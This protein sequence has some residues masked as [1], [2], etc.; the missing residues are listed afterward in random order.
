MPERT[1]LPGWFL[2]LLAVLALA[3]LARACGLVLHRP[4]LAYANNYDQI[5]YSACLDLAP[6]RPGERADTRTARRAGKAESRAEI[7]L[8]RRFRLSNTQF[9]VQ[10]TSNDADRRQT[11]RQGA[12]PTT[13]VRPLFVRLVGMTNGGSGR[14]ADGSAHRPAHHGAGDGPGRSLLL[15]RMAAGGN[16]ERRDS[17]GEDG[18]GADRETGHEAENSLK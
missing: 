9:R 4:L 5:R 11:A 12:T 14:A 18:G 15:G 17:Q 3:A 10:I 13:P 1:R 6:W 2:L 7:K 16:R 8:C